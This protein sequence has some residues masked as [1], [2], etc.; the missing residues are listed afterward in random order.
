MRKLILLVW[1]LG[2]AAWG[3]ETLQLNFDLQR[4]EQG[5]GVGLTVFLGGDWL[6]FQDDK[7]WVRHDFAKK[8]S[9]SARESGV[10]EFSLYANIG[11]RVAE[12]QNRASVAA[13]LKSS[14][15]EA[16]KFESESVLVEHLFGIEAQG[17][18][19]PQRVE[20]EDS[21]QFHFQDKLLL[22]YSRQGQALEPEQMAEFTRFLR[23]YTGGHP[24]ALKE[25]GE[26]LQIP[27]TLHVEQYNVD[28]KSQWKLTLKSLDSV[29]TTPEFPTLVQIADN[30]LGKLIREVAEMT[31]EEITRRHSQTLEQAGEAHREGQWLLASVRYLEAVLNDGSAL[32]EDFTKERATFMEQPQV[33]AF[34]QALSPKDTEQLKMS[35]NT[36]ESLKAEVPTVDHVLT[37]LQGSLLLGAGQEKEARVRLMAALTERPTISS[38]WKDLGEVYYRGYFIN[39]AWQCW[40]TGRSL[41]PDN[42][43]FKQ[44][45]RLEQLLAK[46][47][48]EFF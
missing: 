39:E 17:A 18:A 32:A 8:R 23:Y 47:Y 45:N 4:D 21:V 2:A 35:L 31:V 20:S 28:K 22:E 25:I 34:F 27:E 9:Y 6:E 33:E 16:E 48:P 26:T 38:A 14:G 42:A 40:D 29:E 44:V 30:E 5:D 24:E 19:Q 1:L 10:Q 46:T 41:A 11:F 43:H 37:L 12:L 13:A 7:M 15:A 3:Q 36:L